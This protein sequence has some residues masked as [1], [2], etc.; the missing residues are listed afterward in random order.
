M[1][2][3]PKPLF[4][5]E[6]LRS[7]EPMVILKAIQTKWPLVVQT[8]VKLSFAINALAEVAKALAER[9]A[10]LEEPTAEPATPRH[11]RVLPV[12]ADG[13][14]VAAEDAGKQKVS[15]QQVITFGQDHN[16]KW[17]VS[18]KSGTAWRDVLETESLPVVRAVIACIR[19]CQA[20]PDSQ[21]WPLV[22]ELLR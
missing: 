9:N 10:E 17:V 20:N 14:E 4:D 5:P 13:E 18:L 22:E 12:R 6:V 21:A 1:A 3:Q 15:R 19:E 2:D 16:G 8:S 11:A 7:T